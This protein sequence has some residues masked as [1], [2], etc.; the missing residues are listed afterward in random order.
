MRHF[1]G[2]FVLLA[3]LAVGCLTAVKSMHGT[4][5]VSNSRYIT[6]RNP[7]YVQK[8]AQ[9]SELKGQPWNL[10]SRDRLLADTFPIKDEQRTGF[11]FGHFI[12]QDSEGKKYFACDLY[13]KVELNFVAEGVMEAGEFT[14]MKVLAPCHASKDLNTLEP[15]WIP[16]GEIL[17]QSPSPFLALDFPSDVHVSFSN[18]TSQWPHEWVLQEVRLM[19][20]QT[21]GPSQ[22]PKRPMVI[23]W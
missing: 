5:F 13:N 23:N 2:T 15:V 22:T 6:V 3:G 10:L 9:F 21:P 20:D 16:Q 17:K 7:A 8:F 11:V 4:F 18:L 19:Q 12:T 14:K 1:L